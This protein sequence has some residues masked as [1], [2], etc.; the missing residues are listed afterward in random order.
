MEKVG[1]GKTFGLVIAALLSSFWKF[2]PLLMS[3][4]LLRKMLVM[5]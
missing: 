3:K 1:F 2:I 5:V 4:T